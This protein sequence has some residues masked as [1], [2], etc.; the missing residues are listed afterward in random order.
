MSVWLLWIVGSEIILSSPPRRT[1][2]KEFSVD[3]VGQELTPLPLSWFLLKLRALNWVD[4]RL[5]FKKYFSNWQG[6]RPSTVGWVLVHHL[7]S[8]LQDKVFPLGR[9]HLVDPDIILEGGRSVL[10]SYQSNNSPDQKRVLHDAS[11]LEHNLT[12]VWLKLISTLQTG[13]TPK[14]RDHKKEN[15]MKVLKCETKN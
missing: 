2:L 9:D 4:P 8:W 1:D 13:S 11:L 12:A 15:R 7:S 6:W 14:I 5:L 10:P 3:V